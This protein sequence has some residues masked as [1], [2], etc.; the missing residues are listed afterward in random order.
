MPSAVPH[1]LF[2]REVG[3][4]PTLVVVHGGP[5]FDHRYL[6]PEMDGLADG[7]RLVYYDQRGR[8]ASFHERSLDVTMASEVADLDAVRQAAGA[9]TVALL[10]HSWGAVLAMEYARRHPARVSHL[11]L[12][13]PAPPSSAA[14]A[15]TRAAITAMRTPEELDALA[16]WR[17]DPRYQVGDIAADLAVYRIHFRPAMV[18]PAHLDAVLPRL[19][20]GFRPEGILAARAIEDRL[21]AETWESNRYDLLPQLAQLDMPALVVHG[22]R[23]FIPAHVAHDLASAIPGCE[24]VTLPNCGHFAFLE[25][26]ERFRHAVTAFIEHSQG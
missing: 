14:A 18:D 10:G 26:P 8:G 16:A 2:V 24:L 25:Q 5:D 1:Q 21:Y 20:A 3:H 17:V 12:V 11:V 9:D 7:F 22:D 13:N 23:D 6:L 4:G 15:T 19:R